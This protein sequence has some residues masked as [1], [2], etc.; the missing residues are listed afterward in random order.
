[1]DSKNVPVRRKLSLFS[2]L[3]VGGRR[4]PLTQQPS[5]AKTAPSTRQSPMRKISTPETKLNSDTSIM[6]DNESLLRRTFSKLGPMFEFKPAIFTADTSFNVSIRY[7]I[8]SFF[9]VA[10]IE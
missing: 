10:I 2:P 9:T 7:T 6:P 4:S 1:M 8:I 5:S 3:G